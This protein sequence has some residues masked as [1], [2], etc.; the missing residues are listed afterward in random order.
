MVS[1]VPPPPVKEPVTG[2]LSLPVS[3]VAFQVPIRHGAAA[4]VSVVPVGPPDEVAAAEAPADVV[5]L[6]LPAPGVPAPLLQPASPMPSAVMAT[7]VTLA[8]DRIWFLL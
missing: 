5:P 4:P 2:P 3:P 6:L 7:M 1:R 8:V